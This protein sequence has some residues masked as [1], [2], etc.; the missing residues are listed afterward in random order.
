MMHRSDTLSS[1][2]PPPFDTDVDSYQ[3]LINPCWPD[4]FWDVS[5]AFSHDR[6]LLFMHDFFLQNLGIKLFS[7]VHGSPLFHWNSGRVIPKLLR[8]AEEIMM[9]FKAYDQ[10]GIGIDLT[11]SNLYLT[12]EHLA[13]T[14]GNNM[15]KLAL[16][17]NSSGRN[18]VIMS[19]DALYDHVR[20]NYP[21]LKTVSSIIKVTN[22]RGGGKLDYYRRLAERYDK[23]MVHPN[24]SDNFKLL[25]QLDAKDKYEILLNENCV[26]QCPIRHKHYESLS[27]TALNFLGYE[28]NFEER[29][30]KNGCAS[31]NVL[32]SPTKT[33]TTQ[34]TPAEIKTL[35]DMGFR[36]FKLQGRG[37][38]S[39][40]SQLFDM[41]R[42][43]LRPEAPGDYL[44]TDLK[45]R[46]FEALSTHVHIA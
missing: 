6:E 43:M 29:R 35:Y 26:R 33:C 31:L 9:A 10:R 25:E 22:E 42:L 8:T 20:R 14:F 13:S 3:N 44:M 4:A 15:L 45:A 30:L 27:R 37:L 40:G 21:A 18:A 34:L 16:K 36:K 2:P 5:G 23:V 17:H 39:S 32:L 12:G 7:L 41:L 19:S 46:F 38:L 11:F 1:S 24:D 28:D